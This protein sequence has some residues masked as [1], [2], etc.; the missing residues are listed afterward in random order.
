M[1]F[2]GKNVMSYKGTEPYKLQ[3]KVSNAMTIFVLSM[4][5]YVPSCGQKRPIFHWKVGF[6]NNLG[7]IF[8]LWADN[9]TQLGIL[10]PGISVRYI[11]SRNQRTSSLLLK[12][13]TK[14]Q[15]LHFDFPK[16]TRY[17]FQYSL[18]Y[19]FVTSPLLGCPQR[20]SPTFSN[21][22]DGKPQIPHILR[23]L[24]TFYQNNLRGTVCRSR[25][26]RARRDR[27]PSSCRVPRG[28]QLLTAQRLGAFVLGWGRRDRSAGRGQ[29]EGAAGWRDGLLLH[30]S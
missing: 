18:K 19:F 7:L 26:Q 30:L 24:L 13:R 28:R 29:Q 10:L 3:F 27:D 14:A 17:V 8:V 25:T 2:I 21:T 9:T 6:S 1:P 12:T 20:K 11:S 22:L 16:I 15:G 4:K 23:H 5:N